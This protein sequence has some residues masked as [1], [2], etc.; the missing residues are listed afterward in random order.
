MRFAALRAAWSTHWVRGVVALCAAAIAAG[1]SVTRTPA[2]DQYR[3]EVAAESTPVSADAWPARLTAGMRDAV[4]PSNRGMPWRAKVEFEGAQ[5][6]GVFSLPLSRRVIPTPTGL[7]EVQ[8]L[9]GSP[10]PDTA[11]YVASED[12][13]RGTRTFRYANWRPDT[14]PTW[15]FPSEADEERLQ[16]YLLDRAYNRAS[17]VARFRLLMPGEDPDRDAD[18]PFAEGGDVPGPEPK[19]L[20]LFVPPISDAQWSIPVPR[21]LL[22]RGWAVLSVDNLN[23]AQSARV[24]MTIDVPWVDAE[25]HQKRIVRPDGS[26]PPEIGGRWMGEWLRDDMADIAYAYEA[27]LDFA[28]RFEPV[29]AGKPVV[30][31]GASLGGIFTPPLVARLGE[32]V[33]A[34]VVIGGGANMLGIIS[35]TDRDVFSAT[36]L[37]RDAQVPV[38]GPVADKWKDV[39]LKTNPLDPVHTAG[40]LARIPT[41]IIDAGSDGIIRPEYGR[42]L[43]ERAGKPERWTVDCGHIW[44]FVTLK[45]RAKEIADWVETNA[46]V[47]ESKTPQGLPAAQ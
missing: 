20:I 44:L 18:D 26:L 17:I 46:P 11:S 31:I 39:Y 14:P 35:S 27:G 43:W 15:G 28:L 1:C 2:V 45:D 37:I 41:L 19:G 10:T 7:V 4:L 9:K 32:R 12:F 6:K 40:A 22:A 25:K 38:R 3:A 29:L 13:L 42:L 5:Y 36:L 24:A 16:G 23:V 47:L 33:S 34:A 21:E 30:V 8:K